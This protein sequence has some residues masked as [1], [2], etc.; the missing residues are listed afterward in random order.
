[1]VR[2]WH[3]AQE[4]STIVQPKHRFDEPRLNIL[5]RISVLLKKAIVY[6][7]FNS[8]GLRMVLH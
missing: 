7:P 8:D 5:P 2:P 3:I 4:G 1:M 6:M